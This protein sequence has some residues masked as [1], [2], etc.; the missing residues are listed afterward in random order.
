MYYQMTLITKMYQFFVENWRC[1]GN[2][3]LSVKET[4]TIQE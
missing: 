3:P 2:R 1:M 4:R